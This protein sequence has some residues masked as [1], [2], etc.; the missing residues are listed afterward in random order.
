M[1]NSLTGKCLPDHLSFP[2]TTHGRS[3]WVW[4]CVCAQKTHPL[5]CGH[6]M[7][8]AIC[9][10]SAFF[11]VL[12]G[13]L[14]HIPFYLLLVGWLWGKVFVW[15]RRSPFP[16]GQ[17]GRDKMGQD[18]TWHDRTGGKTQ[19]CTGRRRPNRTGQDKLSHIPEDCDWLRG[20]DQPFQ[21]LPVSHYCGNILAKQHEIK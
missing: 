6:A 16:E 14:A 2:V 11:W 7:K 10:E 1:P 5:W 3:L 20:I 18:K 9:R 12:A 13:I 4:I 19:V 21:L 17:E 8:E 15:G